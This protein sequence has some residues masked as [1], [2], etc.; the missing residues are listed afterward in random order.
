MDN[1]EAQDLIESVA[2]YRDVLGQLDE[3]FPA[4]FPLW[5]LM[6]KHYKGQQIRDQVKLLQGD[7]PAQEKSKEDD[8][9][10][11]SDRIKTRKRRTKK[12]RT[13]K[14]QTRKI[15]LRSL[16]P[17][18]GRELTTSQVASDCPTGADPRCDRGR[19]SSGPSSVSS[20]SVKS[21]GC[22]PS[23]FLVTGNL[24]ASRRAQQ[25]LHERGRRRFISLA[26]E[27]GQPVDRISIGKL[28]AGGR[29]GIDGDDRPHAVGVLEAEDRP[30]LRLIDNRRRRSAWDRCYS[31]RAIVERLADEFRFRSLAICRP[32]GHWR[33]DDE[34]P[35]VA[36]R[37]PAVA[38]LVTIDHRVRKE[39]R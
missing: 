21:R 20:S 3:P 36:D 35:L 14:R 5:P 11:P 10:K 24:A 26:D 28:D 6:D 17:L 29:H 27:K 13:R 38:E 4:D 19:R 23:D 25:R 2:H 34:L 37:L 32:C 39:G 1:A 31:A 30:S 9:K 7:E 18:S 22:S 12:R 15:R 33:Q 16:L 8:D